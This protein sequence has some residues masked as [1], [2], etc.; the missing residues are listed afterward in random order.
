MVPRMAC[1]SR[2]RVVGLLGFGSLLVHELRYRVAYGDA[3]DATLS[4][5]GHAYLA[6]VTPLVGLLLAALSGHFLWA[7]AA[8]RGGAF[9]AQRRTTAAVFTLVLL[10]IYTGQE[11][12]EGMLASGHPGWLAGVFGHGGWVAVPLCALVGCGLSLLVR[13]AHKLAEA[14][15]DLGQACSFVIVPALSGLLASAPFAKPG[16]PLGWQGAERAP[17]VFVS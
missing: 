15:F 1:V 8:R 13:G 5:H 11:L 4:A 16:R 12:L 9:R 2:L 17:P 3:A 10:S 7:V 14:F 6:V